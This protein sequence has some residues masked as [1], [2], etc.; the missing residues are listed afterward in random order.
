MHCQQVRQGVSRP[1]ARGA[2][3]GKRI[4]SE[5]LRVSHIEHFELLRLF[6]IAVMNTPWRK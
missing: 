5:L 2:V 6:L 4:R 1:P 3:G